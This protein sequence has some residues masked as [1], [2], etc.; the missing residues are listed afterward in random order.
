[1]RQTDGGKRYDARGEMGMI[2]GG[3][4]ATKAVTGVILS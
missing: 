4:A 1:M 3:G 2:G